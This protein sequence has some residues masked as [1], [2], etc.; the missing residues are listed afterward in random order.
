MCEFLSCVCAVCK[1]IR[2][3]PLPPPLHPIHFSSSFFFSSLFLWFLTLCCLE[4]FF[5]FFFFFFKFHNDQI[6]KNYIIFPVLRFLLLAGGNSVHSMTGHDV[7][8]CQLAQTLIKQYW[9]TELVSEDFLAA[10]TL[11][12]FTE[13]C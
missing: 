12:V 4:T 5:F 6:Y 8:A 1:I 10:F 3:A 11:L 9:I 13:Y 2:I 7:S